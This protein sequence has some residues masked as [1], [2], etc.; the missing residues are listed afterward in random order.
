MKRKSDF[1]FFVNWLK[2]IGAIY[3]NVSA[4]C[5]GLVPGFCD[6]LKCSLYWYVVMLLVNKKNKVDFLLFDFHLIVQQFVVDDRLHANRAK[7]LHAIKHNRSS[8]VTK[9]SLFFFFFCF[10]IRNHFLFFLYCSLVMPIV[11]KRMRIN[12]RLV[13]RQRPH[14]LQLSYLMT[15]DIPFLLTTITT[16]WNVDIC[17]GIAND[18][19]FDNTKHWHNT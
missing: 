8:L 16:D 13:S 3:C 17:N 7:L 11:R 10:Q 12:S 15:I 19:K 2:L 18:D 4:V 9:K 5:P 1:F 14:S 6:T